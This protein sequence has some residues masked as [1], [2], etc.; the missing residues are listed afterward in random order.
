MHYTPPWLIIAWAPPGLLGGPVPRPWLHRQSRQPLGNAYTH[1][2]QES[3]PSLLGTTNGWCLGGES[4]GPSPPPGPASSTSSLRPWTLGR[5]SPP[6]CPPEDVHPP[7]PPGGHHIAPAGGGGGAWTPH[8]PH[9]WW[10]PC[11]P[12]T[13]R[14]R[15]VVAGRG[16]DVHTLQLPH[17]HPLRVP[18]QRSE[19]FSCRARPVPQLGPNPMADPTRM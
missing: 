13:V 9:P 5:P 15:T 18:C 12:T 7:P 1:S 3:A 19:A 4:Q 11:R 17:V 2:Q 8:T 14:P 6:P 10:S 16:E